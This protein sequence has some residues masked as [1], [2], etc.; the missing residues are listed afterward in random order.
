MGRAKA[1]YIF[2]AAVL[3]IATNL[4]ATARNGQPNS[5]PTPSPTP[6]PPPAPVLAAPA[7]G[8][9]VVQPIALG[10]NAVSDPDGPIGSYTWQ[11]GTTSTFTT[12]VA[13]GFQNMD[14]DSSVPTPTSAKL[15]G[16]PNGTYFWRVKATQLVGGVT[17]SVDSPWSAVRTFT[18]TGLGP[19]PGTPAFTTPAN[20]AQFHIREFYDLKWSAVPNAHYYVLEA[21]DD[22][23]FSYPLTLTTTTM[24][25]GTHA[26]D[27]WGNAIPNI[28]YRVRAVSVDGVRGL[29]SATVAVHITN[30]APVPPAVSQVSPAAGATVALPFFLDWTDTPNPQIPGYLVE[31]NPSSTFG[32]VNQS[33]LVGPSRSDYMITSDVLPRAITSGACVPHTAMFT[34]RGRRFAP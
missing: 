20:N 24:T 15:S 26:N 2:M 5:T 25:F 19:A 3:S 18:V 34:V 16:L 11:V 21:D 33:V 17:F 22:P 9:S 8:A 7:A 14:S 28:Y 6:A 30:A 13:S 27:G 23:S 31:I 10:W 32:D 29:P 12:I 1:F 4:T